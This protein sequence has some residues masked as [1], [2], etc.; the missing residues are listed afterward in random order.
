L[1]PGYFLVPRKESFMPAVPKTWGLVLSAICL[2]A[3]ASTAAIAAGGA[4]SL[5]IPQVAGVNAAVD[6]LT[7]GVIGD[8]YPAKWRDV[9]QDSLLDTWYMYNRECVSWAAFQLN[10][11]GISVRNYGN[12]NNWDDDALRHGY[13][14]D[15]NPTPGSIAQTDAGT[16][17]HVAVVDSATGDTVDVED[18]NG[19]GNGE[20]LHHTV[21]KADFKYIHF[22]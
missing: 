5:D 11:H 12:A 7:S 14:V 2:I 10:K 22:Y 4:G 18:Y 21:N 20:Y 17:G 8:D 9:A 1:S 3:P 6:D 15:E 19:R 16:L 13:T